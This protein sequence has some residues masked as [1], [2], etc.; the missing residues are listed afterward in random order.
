MNMGTFSQLNKNEQEESL[1]Q[2]FCYTLKKKKNILEE[3]VNM[4]FFSYRTKNLGQVL[5]LIGKNGPEERV[6]CT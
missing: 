6:K 5:V 1:N 2:N 4:Y 3:S